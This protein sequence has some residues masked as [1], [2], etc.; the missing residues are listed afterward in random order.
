LGNP[1]GADPLGDLWQHEEGE[2]TPGTPTSFFQSG[3]WSIA[4]GNEF[5]FVDY[6][7][8]DF[9]WSSYSGASDAVIMVTFSSINY[10]GDTPRIYG[11]FNITQSTQY[12]NPRIRGRS[13]SV[14][15]QSAND[16]F[17]RIGRIRYRYSS[18]GRR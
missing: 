6:V 10:P 13:M 11:P 1:I 3:W 14:L 8:P 15:V 17:W 7:I 18:A 4:D 9:R 12:I 5:A 2:A 16:V